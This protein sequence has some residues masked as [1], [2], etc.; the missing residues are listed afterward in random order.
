MSTKAELIK[1]SMMR[2]RLLE[3][4]LKLDPNNDSLKD[5]L[6]YEQSLLDAVK[7]AD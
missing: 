6:A 7:S 1:D 2:I 5:L 3:L 4:H